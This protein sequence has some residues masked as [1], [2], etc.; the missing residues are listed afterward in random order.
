M[1]FHDILLSNFIISPHF[2]EVSV[3]KKYS[4]KRQE[5]TVKDSL[6]HYSWSGYTFLFSLTNFI[7]STKKLKRPWKEMPLSHLR[8]VITSLFLKNIQKSA[9]AS[10]GNGL[11]YCQPSSRHKTLQ[12]SHC[13]IFL[14]S[15]KITFS[16][17]CQTI[18]LL[19][20]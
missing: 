20:F 6:P 1:C 12:L 8:K 3:L 19:S 9:Q 2:L 13:H 10:A 11:G 7:D 5:F 18:S 15:G 14:S 17:L 16:P 4:L